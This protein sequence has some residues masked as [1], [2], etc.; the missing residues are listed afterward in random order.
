MPNLIVMA[1]P[2]GA[3]KTT[4]SRH[5]LCQPR[6]VEEFVNADLIAA[7]QGLDEIAAGRLMLRR[8]DDLATARK[9][10]AFETTLSSASL[11]SR[12]R[13]L[14]DHGYVFHLVYIWIPSADMAVQ[15]VAARVRA[16][17]HSIPEAVI[18][19]RYER[20]LHNFFNRYM[21][22]ADAWTMLDN[23]HHGEP[24]RIAERDIGGPLR[25]FDDHLWNELTARY[26]KPDSHVREGRVSAPGFRM[27]EIYEAACSAVSE[28]LARHKAL[29]Q[30]V[31]VWEDGR[32]VLREAQEIEHS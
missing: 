14:Q 21:P 11:Q 22:M 2:N 25:V 17:G 10:F 16:G 19:R 30:S 20:S 23:S 4:T 13:A 32:V 3:G 5:V 24:T 8:L 28:A 15:R 27:H 31:V 29:G 18:R 6:R 26:M 9:D 7:D 1:G 12:I